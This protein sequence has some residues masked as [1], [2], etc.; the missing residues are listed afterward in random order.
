MSTDDDSVCRICFDDGTVEDLISP[1]GCKGSQKYIHRS[2]LEKWQC[3]VLS[4]PIR[5]NRS[6]LSCTICR[7][8]FRAVGLNTYRVRLRSW[9]NRLFFLVSFMVQFRVWIPTT[10]FAILFV[11]MITGH[12]LSFG[13]SMSLYVMYQIAY[14]TFLRPMIRRDIDG[15]MTVGLI[16]V[17][18]P[19]R[20]LRPG[21]VIAASPNMAS[22]YFERTLI[23]LYEYN[24]DGS[25]GIVLNR[26]CHRSSAEQYLLHGY[27]STGSL[28]LRANG[29]EIEYGVGGPVNQWQFWALSNKASEGSEVIL[30][31]L[32]MCQ[33]LS[34]FDLEDAPESPCP[35][36]VVDGSDTDSEGRGED[37]ACDE[38]DRALDAEL[39]NRSYKVPS[40]DHN[41]FRGGSVRVGGLSGLEVETSATAPEAPADG[42]EP[43]RVCVMVGEAVWTGGQLDG[44]IRNGDWK[45]GQ[46]DADEV[47]SVLSSREDLW[48]HVI[49]RFA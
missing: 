11:L 47:L 8:P 26:P 9:L 17:G 46:L 16:R 24:A 34:G 20:G 29:A 22:N 42:N 14:G 4:K 6:A 7:E 32:H 10:I 5:D 43:T 13:L 25:R 1:C 12:P 39:R 44:E 2:C 38:L 15:N 30:P 23:L 27:G 35:A 40:R 33:D 31:G 45:F 21:I 41:R 36:A 28:P 37:P 3:S 49:N 19:V 18:P 48:Q